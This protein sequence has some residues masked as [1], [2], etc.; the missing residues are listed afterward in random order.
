MGTPAAVNNKK[1]LVVE[2]RPRNMESEFRDEPIENIKLAIETIKKGM[3]DAPNPNLKVHISATA[4][5][6]VPFPE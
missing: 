1:I 2:T 6:S 3:L 5:S 4:A